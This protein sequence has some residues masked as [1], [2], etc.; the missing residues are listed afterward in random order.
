MG[1]GRYGLAFALRGSSSIGAKSH[2][3]MPAIQY[4]NTYLCLPLY[5]YFYISIP[6]FYILFK[7]ALHGLGKYWAL[8]TL[9]T[10]SSMA[11]AFQALRAARPEL[12]PSWHGGFRPDLR[13]YTLIGVQVPTKRGLWDVYIAYVALARGTKLPKPTI[14]GA[15]KVFNAVSRVPTIFG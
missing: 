4:Q 12:L 8:S 10:P 13:P 3:T 7:G 6:V 1:F 15:F 9:E 14:A 5:I 11:G 2:R